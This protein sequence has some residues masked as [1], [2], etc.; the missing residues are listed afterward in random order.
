[1]K[2][3]GGCILWTDTWEGVFEARGFVEWNRESEVE[4]EHNEV[5]T[6]K[7]GGWDMATNTHPTNNPPKR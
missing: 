1:M 5:L 3:E 6:A 4:C 2:G 7:D